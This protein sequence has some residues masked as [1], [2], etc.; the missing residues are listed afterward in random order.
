[1]GEVFLAED[2]YTQ[3]RVALK[4]MT[5]DL[6]K[7]PNQRKRFRR[8]AKAVSGLTHPHICTIDDVGETQE[9]NPF[10]V[11]EYVEGQPLDRILQTRR[12]KLRETLNLGIQAAEALEAAH[13]HGL[14]HRDIKPANLMLDKRGQ[15]K[16]MD[17]GL[18]KRFTPTELSG[19]LSSAAHTKTG[20]L[21]GTPQ[22]MSP[23]QA[24]GHS[25]DP[26][27]DIFSLGAVLY[28]L[29]AG[30]RPFLGKTVGESINCVVNQA[31]APLGLEDP[32]F[33]P[34]LD[35]IIF[36]CLE[37]DPDNRYNSAGEL[38]ADLRRLQE[39]SQQA[40]AAATREIPAAPMGL[41]ACEKMPTALWKLAAKADEGRNAALMRLFG[42]IAVMLL[43]A[44]G[45]VWLRGAKPKSPALSTI[46]DVTTQPMSVAVLHLE[47]ANSEETNEYVF[48]GVCDEI[49]AYLPSIE[50]L[51]VLPG[52]S[53]SAVKGD[54]PSEVGPSLH[55]RI[56]LA[57]SVN[58]IGNKLL[59]TTTHRVAPSSSKSGYWGLIFVPGGKADS[60]VS[61]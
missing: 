11:M 24:L 14:V 2:T 52:S 13:A 49:I 54:R 4:V 33:T 9:G 57:G 42:F 29:V 28:E 58:K 23:E 38:A 46:Q 6:A 8:E 3:R 56:V 10:L 32:R 61:D 47:N 30:Q 43:V 51:K 17:F 5:A 50:G 39:T 40:P 48:D 34:A 1:M 21:I 31:P 60:A 35:R 15:V 44:G 53:S 20:M 41:T 27:T 59:V 37:K 12:L 45:C 16:V 36:K 26:R 18:V 7:D 25:L 55:L 19:A 22:Y